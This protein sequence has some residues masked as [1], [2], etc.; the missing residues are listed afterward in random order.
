MQKA[1]GGLQ[2][3]LPP[4]G[5]DLVFGESD[6]VIITV[7]RFLCKGCGICI[8]M[9]PREVY[10]W[11]KDISKKGVRYPLPAHPEKCTKCRICEILCPDFAISVEDKR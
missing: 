10:E 7:D 11:S 1:M 2:M 9:C 3:T 4:I 5:E 6:K 8:D